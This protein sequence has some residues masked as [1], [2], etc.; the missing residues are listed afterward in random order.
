MGNRDR[1]PSGPLS[2]M[3]LRAGEFATM[4]GLVSYD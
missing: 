2:A 1:S 4:G 3:P